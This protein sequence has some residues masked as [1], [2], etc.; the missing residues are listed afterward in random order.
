MTPNPPPTPLVPRLLAI[1]LLLGGG[2]LL[3]II[4]GGLFVKWL[5]PRSGM[6]WDQLA[7]LLGGWMVGGL[8]GLAV[9]L[10][11]F[12]RLPQRSRLWAGAGL[13]GVSLIM[14]GGLILTRPPS[15]EPEAVVREK[16]FQPWFRVKFSTNHSEAVL[17]EATEARRPLPFIEAELFTAKPSLSYVD[18]EFQNALLT[19]SREDLA[20]LLP[21]VEAAGRE[22]TAE[23]CRTPREDDLTVTLIVRMEG[24]AYRGT[25]EADCLADRPA[26]VA[27]AE[28]LEALARAGTP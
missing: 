4:L 14:V 2:G 12:L 18:W 22:A 16:A 23:I 17:R 25:V 6:G 7:D 26:M 27:L 9:G 8:L 24:A 21:L 1:F 5:M 3:G 10:A 20:R 13:V 19:P 28:A 11:L 15:A